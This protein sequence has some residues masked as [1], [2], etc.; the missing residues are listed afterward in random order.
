MRIIAI[1]KKAQLRLPRNGISG[2]CVGLAS[3]PVQNAS[4]VDMHMLVKLGM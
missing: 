4:N 2:L 3:T 1:K